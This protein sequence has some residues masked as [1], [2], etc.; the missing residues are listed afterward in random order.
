[1]SLIEELA[2][3][4]ENDSDADAKIWGV[5]VGRVVDVVDPLMLGRVQ[6][7]IPSIDATDRSA[8][9]LIATPAAGTASGFY[10][11]P[12]VQDEVLVAFE[13]GDLSAPYVVGCLWSAVEVPPLPSPLAKMRVLRTP[14]GHQIMFTETPPSI[15]ITL[16]GMVQSIIM[17]SAGI[18]IIAG[19]NVIKM[20]NDG[21]TINAAATLN[22]VAASALNLTAPNI[23]LN[24]SAATTVQSGGTCSVTAPLVKIN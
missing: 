24:G 10:W 6:V 3:D 5:V 16:A 9:A 2:R 20:T 11:I 7:Q 17:N 21:I 15:V 13:H 23:T 8:W 1:V 14:A 4:D 12:E 18:Q 19:A 22:L